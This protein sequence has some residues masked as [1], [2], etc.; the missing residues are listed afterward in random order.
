MILQLL[1]NAFGSCWGPAQ[2]TEG[3]LPVHFAFFLLQLGFLY[4]FLPLEERGEQINYC[5]SEEQSL[6]SHLYL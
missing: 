1:I 5:V 3:L 2:A 4:S 6:G